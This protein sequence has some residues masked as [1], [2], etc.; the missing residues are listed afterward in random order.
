MV[1]CNGDGSCIQQCC[2]ICYEDEECD[3]PSEVCT[4]GHRSHIKIIGGNEETDMYCQKPC[5]HKCTLVECH[6]FK[7]CR[8]KLPLQI[9]HCYNDMCSTCAV[10]LGKLTFLDVKDECPICLE[11]KDMV[12]I[13][14]KK[15][16]VCIE[17]WKTASETE[18]RPI[19]LTCPLC[20]ES[21]WKW[22]GR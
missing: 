14:C 20:R 17:C 3:V 6:N 21:I 9:L 18:N 7:L 10:M 13:S 15:H 4:C 12:L 19:P 1:S 2:C 22:K 5:Q 16:K 8:K 11:N